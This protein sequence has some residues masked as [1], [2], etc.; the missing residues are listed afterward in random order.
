[1]V[2]ERAFQ[3]ETREA[4]HKGTG[5]REARRKNASFQQFRSNDGL[6]AR[7]PLTGHGI[8]RGVVSGASG[9]DGLGAGAGEEEQRIR[10]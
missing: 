1:M 6:G 8:W 2:L 7:M 3:N 10:R 9:G 5:G 4:F